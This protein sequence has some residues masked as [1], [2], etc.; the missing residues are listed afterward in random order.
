MSRKIPRCQGPCLKNPKLWQNI[1]DI[2]TKKG[3]TNY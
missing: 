1:A 3:S 2:K